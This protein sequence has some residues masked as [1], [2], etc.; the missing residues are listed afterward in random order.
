M[1]TTGSRFAM[2]SE[3]SVI[4]P[5]TR[6]GP[7]ALRVGSLERSVGFYRGVLGFEEIGREGETVTLGA[8]G[9]ALLVLRE[10]PGAR[11][12]P[13]AATGL[14]HFAV[15][16]PSQ[17]ALGHVLR[18]LIEARVAVGQGDHLVSEALYLSDPDGNGIEVY[19]DRP[20][21]TWRWQNGRVQM[22][23]DPVDL[24][25]LLAAA[26]RDDEGATGLPAGTVIGHV[27]LKV[28][29]IAQARVFYH[30][31][32]GFEIVADWSGALFVSAGG[33]HH[34]FGLN[35]WHS[36]G[37]G[38]APAGTSGLEWFTIVLPNAEEEARV[39]GRLEA[40]GIAFERQEGQ[41]VVRDPWQNRVVLKAS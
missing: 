9:V 17:A 23:T 4:H 32:L 26:Q 16:V 10:L 5:E 12:V 28:G 3:T 36:R 6:L 19:R 24:Q 38:P 33:Y 15:L 13:E 20:R 35:T 18:R 37:A 30:K 27:H 22:A 14:Y 2:S 21:E 40:A 39:L 11:P 41:V 29:D 25:G 1:H 8:A 7:V 31:V 34:H